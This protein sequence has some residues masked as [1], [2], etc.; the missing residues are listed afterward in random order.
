[1][2]YTVFDIINSPFK[3]SLIQQA[4]LNLEELKKSKNNFNKINAGNKLTDNKENKNINND[5]NIIEKEN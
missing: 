2:L 4:K 3:D 1:M 5:N